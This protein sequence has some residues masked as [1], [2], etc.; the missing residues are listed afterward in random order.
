M[1]KMEKRIIPAAWQD[2][3]N[4]NVK[5]I[6]EQHRY[7]F[8]VLKDLEGMV[9]AGTCQDNISGIFFS[10][11]HYFDNYLIQEEIY[12]KGLG[13]SGIKE[14]HLKHDIF[15]AGIINL[16][17]E[18]A[19]GKENVCENLLAFMTDFFYGHILDYDVKA[20]EYLRSL[21]DKHS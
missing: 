15:V 19:G 17:D 8:R 1:N 14:H 6:D 16:K 12:F 10:L 3:F 20:A 18:Y 4:V 13:Y 21:G 5:F 11:V 7:F 9:N 2:E